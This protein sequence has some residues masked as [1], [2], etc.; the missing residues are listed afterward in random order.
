[1]I[2]SSTPVHTRSTIIGQPQTYP[3]SQLF[4]AAMESI[5]GRRGYFRPTERRAVFVYADFFF[6]AAFF[7]AAFA[8]LRPR[9]FFTDNPARAASNSTAAG[10]VTASTC[11]PFGT[12]AF[13]V[14]SGTYGP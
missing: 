4:A 11:V 12:E 3:F 13:V 2:V 10:M 7:A 9:P 5:I 6:G 8:G 1:M 14:P